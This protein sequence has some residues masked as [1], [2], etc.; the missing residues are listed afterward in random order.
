MN[1][2]AIPGFET[3]WLVVAVDPDTGQM[4]VRGQYHEK[5]EDAAK[6]VE[7]D[8]NRPIQIIIPA[9]VFK[10]AESIRKAS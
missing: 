3:N 1:E 8:Y 5:L 10:E 7:S 2:I 9:L 6:F 4:F